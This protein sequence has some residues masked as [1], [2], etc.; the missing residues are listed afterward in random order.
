MRRP[1]GK[2]SHKRVY[3]AAEIRDEEDVGINPSFIAPS[4]TGGAAMLSVENNTCLK[5]NN[6]K[7]YLLPCPAPVVLSVS[8]DPNMFLSRAEDGEWDHHHPSYPTPTL[9]PTVTSLG[10]SHGV[11]GKRNLDLREG[12]Q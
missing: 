9:P 10:T 8:R 5:I 2:G 7:T 12:K 6:Q 11:A 3:G 4:Q 1:K